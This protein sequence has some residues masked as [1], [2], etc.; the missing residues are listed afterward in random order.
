M[1][2]LLSF[3]PI[4]VTE[5]LSMSNLNKKIKEALKAGRSGKFFGRSPYEFFDLEENPFRVEVDPFDIDYHIEREQFII[6][7]AKRVGYSIQLFE[8]DPTSTDSNFLVHGSRGSGKTFLSNFFHQNWS[9]WGFSDYET[10]IIDFSSLIELN[11]DDL[12]ISRSYNSFLNQIKT[13]KRPQIVI[14]DNIDY[15][16]TGNDFIPRFETFLKEIK[17]EARYGVFIIGFIRSFT[18][19]TITHTAS[20]NERIFLSLFHSNRFFI[21]NFEN[22]EIKSLLLK[23][24]KKVGKENSLFTNSSL[25]LI[26]LISFGNPIVALKLAD[27]CLTE[28]INLPDLNK[29]TKTITKDVAKRKGYIFSYK[30]VQ[31]IFESEESEDTELSILFTSKRQ[32]VILSIFNHQFREKYFYPSETTGGLNP[33]E[34]GKILNVNMSTLSYHIKPLVYDCTFPLLEVRGHPLDARSKM[35][36]VNMKS[37]V[38]YALELFMIHKYLLLP[39]ESKEYV[40]SQIITK[41]KE[42]N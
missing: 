27:D 19:Y 7:F 1:A 41:K 4:V 38:S 21:K 17:E 24:L 14:A 34:L 5:V 33:S 42:I 20:F 28:L 39:I 25:D 26:A 31:S 6:D 10:K 32:E 8:S 11:N 36:R 12:S 35:Y 2:K 37:H 29:V 22:K 30:I 9:I 40:P 16:I 13:S 3:T 15:T 18:L 23:R